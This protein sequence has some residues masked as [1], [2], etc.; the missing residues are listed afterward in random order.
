VMLLC[1]ISPAQRALNRVHR[2]SA[3]RPTLPDGK[4]PG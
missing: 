1:R 2:T 3:S 4:L